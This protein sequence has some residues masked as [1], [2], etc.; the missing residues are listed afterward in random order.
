MSASGTRAKPLDLDAIRARADK[1]T[2]GPWKVRDP[3]RRG[4]GR[5]WYIGVTSAEFSLNA[6]MWAGKGRAVDPQRV[7][8]GEFIAHAREDIPELLAEIERLR[9]LVFEHHA[10]GVLASVMAGDRCPVCAA[11][12]SAE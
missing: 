7:A 2:P 6:E 4:T 10:A 8:D 1:A 11:Q 5:N 3:F 12:E 9:R